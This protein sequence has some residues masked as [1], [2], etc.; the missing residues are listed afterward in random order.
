MSNLCLHLFVEGDKVRLVLIPTLLMALLVAQIAHV[1]TLAQGDGA[2]CVV[3]T[4]IFI[5]TLPFYSYLF[6]VFPA[7]CDISDISSISRGNFDV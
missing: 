7:S 1:L 5:H 6:N 3:G 4:E 2:A